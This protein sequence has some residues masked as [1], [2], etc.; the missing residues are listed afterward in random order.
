[1][2]TQSPSAAEAADAGRLTEH[3]LGRVDP[4]A[5]GP[6]IAHVLRRAHE[7]AMTLNAPDEARAILHVA[8]S[9]ADELAT[10]NP[11]FDRLCFIRAATGLG[12]E[13]RHAA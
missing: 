5:A 11:E 13:G 4:L 2:T 6:L 1:M 8:R 10:T 9:F 7:T 3:P 12:G